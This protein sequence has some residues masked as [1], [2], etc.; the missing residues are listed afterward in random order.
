MLKDVKAEI[1]YY[2]ILTAWKF[3]YT[4]GGVYKL[5]E[6]EKKGEEKREEEREK[7]GKQEDGLGCEEKLKK[8]IAIREKKKRFKSPKGSIQT[9]I[10]KSI[11]ITI[12]TPK[13]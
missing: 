4:K 5:G 7:E 12:P 13:K 9:R 10:E 11:P 6:G 8:K 1:G 3:G 2:R